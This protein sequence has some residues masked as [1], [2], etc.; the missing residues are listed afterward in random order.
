MRVK[1]NK[2]VK[3]FFANSSLEMVYFEAIANALDAG[4]K[5]IDINISARDYSQPESLTVSIEDDGAGLTDDRFAKFSNLFDVDE[6]SHKGLGRLVFLCYFE[7]ISVL[8][9]FNRFNQRTV[10]FSEGFDGES[11]VT[12]HPTERSSGTKFSMNGYTLTKLAQY[13]FV[14]PKHL[15]NRILTEFYSRLYKLK[16]E[17]L[18]IEINISST[19]NG[20]SAAETLTTDEMP[21][22]Q[23]IPLVNSL[24]L[25]ETMELHYLIQDAPME[26]SSVITAISV[27]NRTYKIDIIA[28]ENLP[29]GH[30]MVFLLY[31]DSFN[32]RVDVSR[33]NLTLTDVEL[34]IVKKSFRD[35]IAQIIDEKLPRIS[36]QNQERKQ[37]LVNQFPHLNGYFDV[38]NIGFASQSDVL[39]KAQERFFKAQ[40]DIL[41]ATHLSEE[42]YKE[43]L[44]L[45]SRA[46]T[47]YILFRQII[48]KKLQAID[49]HDL[50]AEIHKL[51]IPM[52]EQFSGSKLMDDLY[53]SNVWVLDDKYMTYDT[54][55]SDEE[56]TTVI[57]VITEG[58]ETVI[59]S[60]RPDI[61]LIFSGNPNAGRKVDVVIVELKRKGL[62]NEN[63][64]IVE[65]QLENRARRLMNY[66]NQNIQQVWFYGI[67]EFNDEYQLHLESEYHQLYSNGKVYYKTKEVVLQINPRVAVPVGMYI[68]DF[69]A[70]VNDADARNST[71]LNIIKNKFNR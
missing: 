38:D 18:H 7:N 39:K 66:Y 21:V 60:D 50:E 24:E 8:S 51:I 63:N 35:S 48:I 68:M 36:Q 34:L 70:V 32:G 29:V 20:A 3:M 14:Q 5:K 31:S 23:M 6:S 57:D 71:F 28:P 69:D 13:S 45:S 47:E 65:I 19:I 30:K 4:A 59:D 17:G 27:D 26:I 52:R 43:T 53:L 49:K 15:K 56:M 12:V 11:V 37:R 58:E 16:Q 25:F 61:A 67:V 44:E 33:Q 42:Q 55:L 2:A 22:M 40:R 54:V 64:S 41:G 62:T 1:L 10:Q 9:F 46:L